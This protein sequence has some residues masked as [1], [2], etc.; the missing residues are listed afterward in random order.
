MMIYCVFTIVYYSVLYTYPIFIYSI[1]INKYAFVMI[2]TIE[3]LDIHVIRIIYLYINIVC[4]IILYLY[5]LYIASKI[6]K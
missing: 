4:F 1:Y 2:N 3:I 5:N 6:N